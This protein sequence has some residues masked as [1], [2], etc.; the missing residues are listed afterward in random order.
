MELW[1]PYKLV[2]GVIALLI[3]CILTSQLVF[4]F[5]VFCFFVSFCFFTPSILKKTQ[6]S[7]LWKS[8]IFPQSFRG[9]KFPNK[10]EVS[11]N[12]CFFYSNSNRLNRDIFIHAQKNIQSIQPVHIPTKT[13]LSPPTTLVGRDQTPQQRS[14]PFWHS[15][16]LVD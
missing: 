15:I 5:V 12:T 6:M 9:N 16:I 10:N 2:T 11:P 14:K 8:S 4:F 3:P 1:G 13:N 7:N